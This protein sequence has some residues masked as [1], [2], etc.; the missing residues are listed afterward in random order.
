MPNTLTFGLRPEDATLLRALSKAHVQ[1]P[2]RTRKRL[3][4]YYHAI[5]PL[6]H[7]LPRVLPKADHDLPFGDTAAAQIFLTCR[8]DRQGVPP[9]Q[10]EHAQVT[11]R[12]LSPKYH[13]RTSFSGFPL[14]SRRIRAPHFV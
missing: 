6:V 10:T 3:R 1:R 5:Q 14:A 9:Y 7:A 11:R 8:R 12:L 13:N 2:R 4:K